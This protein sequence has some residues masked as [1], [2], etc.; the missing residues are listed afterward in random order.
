MDLKIWSPQ[1]KFRI[2]QRCTEVT[3]A[4]DGQTAD[5]FSASTRPT[6]VSKLISTAGAMGNAAPNRILLESES[7]TNLR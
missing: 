3:V 6:L 1:N 7:F 4:I 5:R 2:Q